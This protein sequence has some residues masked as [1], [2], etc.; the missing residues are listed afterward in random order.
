MFLEETIIED[1]WKLRHFFT[2]KELKT[3]VAKNPVTLGSIITKHHTLHFR[4]RY[5][6]GVPSSL[7]QPQ[8]I[9]AIINSSK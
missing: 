4:E 3:R 2:R 1:R 6:F 8:T 9:V 5:P 7:I